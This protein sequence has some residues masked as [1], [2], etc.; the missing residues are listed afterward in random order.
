MKTWLG[1][2]AG[3]LTATAALAAANPKPAGLVLSYTGF[4][5]ELA[6]Y[7][8]IMAGA[9]FD[10]GADTLSFVHYGTC[11]TVEVKGG[12][13]KVGPDDF[14]AGGT[15]KELGKGQCPEQVAIKTGGVSGGVLMRAALTPTVPPR[16][17]CVLAGRKSRDF[18]AVQIVDGSLVVTQ[19]PLGARKIA[20]PAIL[21][22][23]KE[24]RTYRLV[25]MPG[26]PVEP[27]REVTAL[28]S[29]PTGGK[30]CLL[31]LD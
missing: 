22:P 21:P 5:P 1:A 12:R 30:L 4:H 29:A 25:F 23:L 11:D 13:L 9:E 19:L 20:L 8:E 28:V 16:F 18:S 26:N 2:L 10:L 7:S 14:Q 3:V 24:G 15:T 6:P 27:P 31:R 17:D